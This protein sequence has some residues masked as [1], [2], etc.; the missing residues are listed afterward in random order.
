[1]QAVWHLAISVAAPTGMTM[2]LGET[3]NVAGVE[4][5]GTGL[6]GLTG[7]QGGVAGSAAHGEIV[8]RRNHASIGIVA[9]ASPTQVKTVG[10]GM[11]DE[12]ICLPAGRLLV[13]L[14]AATENRPHQEVVEIL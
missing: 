3:L 14:P 10:L 12:S 7:P 4:I 6:T 13:I 8:N 1:M 2:A 5:I 11:S 9:P